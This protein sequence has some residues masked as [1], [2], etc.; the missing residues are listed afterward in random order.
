MQRKMSDLRVQD[1]VFVNV[2]TSIWT[3]P[4]HANNEEKSRLIMDRIAELIRTNKNSISSLHN[5]KM[6]R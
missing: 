5:P 4:V 6:Q 2:R 3:D 1:A